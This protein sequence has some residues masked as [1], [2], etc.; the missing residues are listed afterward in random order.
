MRATISRYVLIAA[1]AVQAMAANAAEVTLPFVGCPADGQVG[2]IDPPAGSA[3]TVQVDGPLPVPFA[4]YKGAQGSG[5]FAPAGWHCRVWYGS[6]GS[7]MIVTPKPLK[8]PYFPAPAIAG[9]AVQSST[10]FA[11][12]SGRFEAA[13]LCAML[14]PTLTRKF[15]KDVEKEEVELFSKREDKKKYRTD[16]LKYLSPHIVE[17]QTPANT[18]GLGTESHIKAGNRPIRGI[19]VLNESEGTPDHVSVL[20]TNLVGG[21]LGEGDQAVASLILKLNAVCMSA[22]QG[23]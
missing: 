23:C 7:F 8:P 13:R 12:T 1:I 18:R 14:F 6:N 19:A 10:V 2:A 21:D 5:V 9:P 3:Q 20:R 16:S 17:F 11:D 22:D 15:V 4:Y